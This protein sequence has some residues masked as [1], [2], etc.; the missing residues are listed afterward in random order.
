MIVV[1]VVVVVVV[2]ECC[3]FYIIIIVDVPRPRSLD[4]AL[5]FTVFWKAGCVWLEKRSRPPGGLVVVVRLFSRQNE[6]V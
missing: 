1:V 4:F 5:V 3:C 6:N 2:V